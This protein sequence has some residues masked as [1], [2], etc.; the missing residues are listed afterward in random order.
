MPSTQPAETKPEQLVER[1]KG[2]SRQLSARQL[3][4][5]ALGGAIGTGLFLGTSLSVPMAGPAIIIT[6][7]IGALVAVLLMGALSEMAV[8]HPTAGSFGVYA[9]MYVNPWAGFSV[10]PAGGSVVSIAASAARAGAATS[11][12]A[13]SRAASEAARSGFTR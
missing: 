13:D 10:G 9:E 2:L 1:E 3:T 7:A 8:V 4:M 6:Y 12:V 11:G 5:I